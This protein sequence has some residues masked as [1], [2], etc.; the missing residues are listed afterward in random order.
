MAIANALAVSAP[1]TAYRQALAAGKAGAASQLDRLENTLPF[2]RVLALQE[3]VSGSDTHSVDVPM[4]VAEIREQAA[5]RLSGQGQARSYA[6][7]TLWAVLAKAAGDPEAADILA[8][9]DELVRLSG[10]GAQGAWAR[11]APGASDLAM[12]AWIGQDLPTRYSK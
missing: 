1:E 3:E 6:V 12:K 2:E 9:I 8:D 11:Y 5:M 10:T 7:A 4:S